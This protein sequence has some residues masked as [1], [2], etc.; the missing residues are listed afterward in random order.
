MVTIIKNNNKSIKTIYHIS[1][2][3][4]R[5]TEEHVNIYTHV[6]DNLYKYFNTIDTNN[7]IIV[8]T[9]DILHNK[10]RLTTT[11][12]TL[13]IDFFEKLS[14][15]MSTI[16]IPGNHDFNEKNNSI[17]TDSLTTILYKRKFTNLYYLKHSGIYRYNN[18]LFGVSSIIDNTFI[19]ASD[20][21]EDGIKIG[22]F[23]GPVSN[24]KNSLGFEFSKNS[25]TNFDG[26][27]MVLLGDIHY[28]QY[29]NDDKTI[30][31]ASSLISQNFSETDSYHGVLVWN[32]LTRESKYKIIENEY[33]YEEIDIK[34]NI[35]F[36]KNK[37]IKLKNLELPKYGKIKVNSV[38][39]DI[40]FYNKIIFDIKEK[41]PD[42]NIVHNKLQLSIYTP[43]K[44]LQ[45]NEDINTS[46][47]IESEIKKVPDNIR[48]FVENILVKEIK[49]VLQ[50]VDVKLNWRLLSLEFSNMFSY[51]P[52]NIIDFT[53]LTF[54]EITGMIG[55]NS[56]G[57]SSLIDILLFSLFDDY[58]RNYQDRN[59]LLSGTIINSKEKTF[60]CKVSFMVD[61][62]VYYIEK[63]GK[64]MTAKTD[65]T[66]DTF[67]FLTY[68]FYKIDVSQNNNKI[69]LN[70]QDRFETLNKITKLIGNYDD[71]CIASVCLQN[72]M[73]DKIDFFNMS[74]LERK[75]FL[76]ERLKFDVFKNIESKYKDLLKEAK[77]NLKNIET[78][79]DY[80]NYDHNIDTKIITLTDNINTYE[81]KKLTLEN[82][83]TEMNILLSKLYQQ[84]K[85]INISYD[86]PLTCD[87]I[88]DDIKL[89][90]NKLAKIK[91]IDIDSIIDTLY[92]D[93]M[94]L[95]SS[96][97]NS[98]DI[99]DI[100][101]I[102]ERIDI[103]SKSELI[104]NKETIIYNN[105]IFEK[106]KLENIVKLKSFITLPG[107]QISAIY[108]NNPQKILNELL[109]I[110]QQIII[111]NFD[112]QISNS[113]DIINNIMK[114][115]TELINTI[116]HTEKILSYYDHIIIEPNINYLYNNM[117]DT[118][119]YTEYSNNME[120][121][122]K[123]YNKYDKLYHIIESNK[124]TF[125][126]LNTALLNSNKDCSNCTEHNN[127][128]K[129]L[130]S[131]LQI[132]NDIHI[133]INKFKELQKMKNAYEQIIV[134]H[135]K[136]KLSKC[137]S[138]LDINET[139]LLSE[140]NNLISLISQSQNKTIIDHK[141]KLQQHIY[142]IQYHIETNSYDYQY[143]QLKQELDE[144]NK[145]NNIITNKSI[146]EKIIINKNKISELKN[147]KTQQSTFINKL[148]CLNI[149]LDNFNNSQYNSNIHTQIK[150]ASDDI[151]QLTNM[152]I[153][154]NNEYTNDNN[155]LKKLTITKN[156]YN[157]YIKEANELTLNINIYEN[158][159][160]LTCAKGIPRQ[161]INGKLQYVENEV[162][163]IITPFINK[164]IKITK[165]I[166]DIKIFI[167][168]G[169]SKYNSTGGME[170]FI[171][172]IA[173]KIAFTHT[174]N[175]PQTGI[176]FID[177]GVSVLD[178]K[179]INNF[180]IISDF[181]KK[182]YN[183]IILITHIDSF[184]DYT[185]DIININKNKQKQSS[186]VF[187]S[188]T[189]INNI[190]I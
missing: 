157:K 183:H 18:I 48:K 2:I 136:L 126:I 185:F 117:L 16:I 44:S 162:N 45:N 76:N 70:G 168:D 154:L 66:F 123:D 25:I 27:D 122:L 60:S 83:I 120:R 53:K 85:Y 51:G 73:R 9:G 28:Y 22:L 153:S 129:Q 130:F 151:M 98:Y 67:K 181:I 92:N 174:F 95:S 15:I 32:V 38:D 142:N 6:F 87:D 13:C 49:L 189:K 21:T 135:H 146:L 23:H 160:K 186:V 184:F 97:N 39:C 148:N 99:K 3:H 103:L 101:S 104:K 33:R 31:Y 78:N 84:L 147:I 26:Y 159:I 188:I 75:S 113:N 173:F 58:S 81:S 125:T 57:K 89:Y 112:I 10:D 82:N 62:T 37:K 50:D 158:V 140:K 176:L 36:Y 74:P 141:N 108:Y 132:D 164:Q 149:L 187:P 165:E 133:I 56:I 190:I 152:I 19:K 63:L 163:N 69:Q 124:Q 172:S 55:P 65:Y 77:I 41:Y 156:N 7:S 155:N 5:N 161:I 4:I 54:D 121:L 86:T 42:I 131:Q 175:L 91:D 35:I 177:E 144:L 80:I 106:Q 128:I 12:E 8:I 68:D 111:P 180:S 14:S 59:R 88:I 94:T 93:N 182:Y 127:N 138:L 110:E 107:N 137:K 96:L 1:D 24:S 118:C 47:I 134:Y 145:L 150:Q 169:Y 109:E 105:L 139:I 11:S 143:I 34:N 61:N 102:Q 20:I 46:S 166:E 115:I 29:L 79:Y 40:E 179:H 43:N 167:Q 170:T 71:F 119:N 90:Q 72:N 17:I 116:K 52:N 114:N 178:K 30:A 64:R 100:K 171:I